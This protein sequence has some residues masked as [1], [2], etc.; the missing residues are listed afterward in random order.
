[1]K[2]IFQNKI[3]SSLARIVL[4]ALFIYA[5]LDKL[6]NPSEFAKI[7]YYY[8]ILPPGYENL[9]AIFL[10]WIELFTGLFLIVDKFS[11]GGLFIYSSLIII[12]ILALLQAQIRGLDI[13]CGCFSVESSTT[14]EI[15]LRIVLDIVMLFFS[16]N[17][18]IYYKDTKNIL[19]ENQSI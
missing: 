11:K 12:Y 8:R 15:W 10:P 16:I 3:F 18:Y 4:G 9:F 6:A 1:M 17:L 13:S 7:I 19:S 5:S 2:E 14:S